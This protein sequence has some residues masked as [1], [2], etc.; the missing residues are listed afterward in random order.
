M[1][2]EKFQPELIIYTKIPTRINNIYQIFKELFMEEK[3]KLFMENERHVKVIDKQQ[4][5]IFFL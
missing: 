4:S 1:Q 5:H 2:P 3:K